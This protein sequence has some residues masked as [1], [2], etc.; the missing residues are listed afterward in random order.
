V[1]IAYVSAALNTA[2]PDPDLDWDFFEKASDEVGL[3]VE[4]VFWNDSEIDWA[5]FD[6]AIIRS[7]W[8]YTSQ[9]D[10]F[11]AWARRVES[12]TTLLNSYATI[13]K[14]TDK[15]YLLEL[16]ALVPVIPTLFMD[17]TQVNHEDL[18]ELI[19]QAKA[20]AVKPNI[21]A[22]AALAVRAQT[23]EAAL[24]AIAKIH[25]AGRLAMVQPYLAE[26][27]TQGEIAIVIIDGEISHAVK[28]VPA[29]TKGGHGDAQAATE[30]TQE[31]RDFVRQLSEG[32]AEWGSLLYARVDVVPTDQGLLLM[33]L[34]LTEPTLF[35]PQEPAAAKKLANSILKRL[36]R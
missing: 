27:D 3:K 23:I 33:E 19:I 26:V 14:N 4:K 6:L 2:D 30:I 16:A 32:V 20:I 36:T 31:M 5:K 9:R 12:Q 11:L 18:Q 8:D 13:S 10:A 7:P 29:L 25:Q 24:A 34:E 15:R 21:G 35:F 28:K 1:L 17:A 22:G